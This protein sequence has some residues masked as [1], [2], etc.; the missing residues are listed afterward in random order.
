[1]QINRKPDGKC[2]N[3]NNN[4]DYT[5]KKVNSYETKQVAIYFENISSKEKNQ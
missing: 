2:I 3:G 4:R 5:M 1:M